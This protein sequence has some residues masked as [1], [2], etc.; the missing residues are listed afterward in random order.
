MQKAWETI[1]PAWVSSL[2]V[3]PTWFLPTYSSSSMEVVKEE[4]KGFKNKENIRLEYFNIIL[5]I[6]KKGDRNL[7]PGR[8]H[9]G[10]T[11]DFHARD[12]TPERHILY[13]KTFFSCLSSCY[14]V[15]NVSSAV[16]SVQQN[17]MAKTPAL[18]GGPKSKGKWPHK[19]IYKTSRFTPKQCKY[20]ADAKIAWQTITQTAWH[21]CRTGANNTAKVL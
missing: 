6:Q 5:V 8:Q 18:V 9:G 20:R 13:P 12:W 11:L 2:S 4:T 3:A 14:L 1:L 10:S 19:V 15:P 17:G 16:T 7:E 21:T